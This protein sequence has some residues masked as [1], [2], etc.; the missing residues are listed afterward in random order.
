MLTKNSNMDLHSTETPGMVALSISTAALG[1]IIHYINPEA[2]DVTFKIINEGFQL[3][4]WTVSII[5]GIK[6]IREIRERKSLRDI[7][8]K[9]KK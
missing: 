6:V 2:L 8:K 9:K 1:S 4:A 5:A 3:V 7:F